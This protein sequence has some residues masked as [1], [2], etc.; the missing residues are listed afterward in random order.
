MSVPSELGPEP[1]ADAKIPVSPQMPARVRQEPSEDELE[2]ARHLIAHSQSYQGPQQRTESFS[3]VNASQP[4]EPSGNGDFTPGGTASHAQFESMPQSYQGA[5]IDRASPMSRSP[6]HQQSRQPTPGSI[7]GG[8]MCSN[9]G[10]TKTPLWRR[11]PAG[12]VI[13]NA[14]GLYYKARNQMRPVGLKRGAAAAAQQQS[15]GQEDRGASP[16]SIQGGA[17]YVSA[18]QST[19][20][21]CPGGGRCNGTGGHDG[22]SGCPAYN[23]RISKTAQVALNHSNGETSFGQVSQPTSQPTGGSNDA[24]SSTNVVVACQNCGTT[25]TPLWRRDEA[26]HT[27]CNACG[28]YYK[29][30]GSHR[31]LQMKKGEIKRRKRVVPAVAGQYEQQPHQT[32]PSLR[33]PTTDE[34]RSAMT[35]EPAPSP[36][37][38]NQ[39]FDANIDPAMQDH[40][41]HHTDPHPRNAPIPVDFTNFTRQPQTIASSTPSPSNHSHSHPS[42][43]SKRTFST[44]ERDNPAPQIAELPYPHAQNTSPRSNNQHNDNIDPSL[45]QSQQRLPTR[46]PSMPGVA[47]SAEREARRTALRKEAESMREMLLAKERELAEM[48]VEEGS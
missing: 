41:Q 17:T 3:A 30:H 37:N 46:S 27:I 12:A 40:H 26:G 28:L 33:E 15:P 38:P 14:C 31:P 13:C 2:A 9:C 20:G 16:T 44:S 18:D 25:I 42:V 7:P 43:P 34:D 19:S 8:Q 1:Q 39:P 10:T 47:G 11:S 24:A 5:S 36:L 6:A 21:T 45:Q 23:N 35:T 29:L 22:C 4:S 32:S 48:G